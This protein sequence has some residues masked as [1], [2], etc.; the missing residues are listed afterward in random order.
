MSDFYSFVISP[1]HKNRLIENT[2]VLRKEKQWLMRT[3]RAP[4]ESCGSVSRWHSSHT[5]EFLPQSQISPPAFWE[6]C[7]ALMCARQY[8]LWASTYCLCLPLSS[9]PWNLSVIYP[10]WQ[11]FRNAPFRSLTKCVSLYHSFLLRNKGKLFIEL[12]TFPFKQ[13]QSSTPQGWAREI[14]SLSSWDQ[15]G[16]RHECLP[17]KGFQEPCSE[18][19]SPPECLRTTRQGR[20]WL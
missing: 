7:P 15:N 5:L 3:S 11:T 20:Q 10:K 13:K 17:F 8:L 2:F 1:I 19:H 12:E 18:G 6:L 4:S 14:H 9:F 16:E